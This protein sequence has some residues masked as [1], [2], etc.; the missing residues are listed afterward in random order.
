LNNTVAQARD[1]YL[2]G[3]SGESS[4]E[5]RRLLDLAETLQ[6]EYESGVR[7][8]VVWRLYQALSVVLSLVAAGVL[9]ALNGHDKVL[10]AST[11]VVVGLI[12]VGMIEVLLRTRGIARHIARDRR[13]LRQVVDLIREVEQASAVAERWPPLQRA[14]FRIRLSR[15]DI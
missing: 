8:L 1:T 6:D 4:D 14:E 2:V 10:L 9:L 7:R 15:F 13:A 5:L 11:A 3:D 12:Y